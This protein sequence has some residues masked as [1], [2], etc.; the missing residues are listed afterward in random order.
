MP[1]AIT[2]PMIETA[3]IYVNAQRIITATNGK[4]EISGRKAVV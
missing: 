2:T 1:T 3:T 4:D